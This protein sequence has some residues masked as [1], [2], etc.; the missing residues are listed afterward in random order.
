[1]QI[2]KFEAP[3]IQEALEAIKKELGPEAVILQTRKHR[4]GFGLLS[5]ALVEV[6]AAVSERVIEK[7]KITDKFYLLHIFLTRN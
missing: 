3:T 6:T 4:K 7:I 5:K 1:M 2:K